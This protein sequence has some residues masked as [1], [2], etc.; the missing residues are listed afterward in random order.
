MAGCEEYQSGEN[1]KAS[2]RVRM[3]GF[4]QDRKGIKLALKIIA[5]IMKLCENENLYTNV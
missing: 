5:N 3:S 4:W 2:C 1:R